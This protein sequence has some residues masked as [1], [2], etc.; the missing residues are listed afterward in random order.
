MNSFGEGGSQD[1]ER[2][3]RLTSIE[4]G[5][6]S[7]VKTPGKGHTQPSPSSNG[8][9]DYLRVIGLAPMEQAFVNL[10]EEL[11]PDVEPLRPSETVRGSRRA[12]QC[13]HV[14]GRGVVPIALPAQ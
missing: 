6:T 11:P 8:V 7:E 12:R 5:P 13:L 4:V 10:H 14:S 1:P 9:V 3:P 2:R